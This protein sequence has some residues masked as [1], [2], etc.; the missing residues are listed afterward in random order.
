MTRN[1]LL[2][3]PS[4][5]YKIYKDSVSGGHSGTAS[6]PSGVFLP[7]LFHSFHF[8]S[9]LILSF[10]RV[11]P[12]LLS[13]LTDGQSRAALSTSPTTPTSQP[14]PHLYTVSTLSRSQTHTH[15]RT[16]AH[17]HARITHAATRTRTYT[18]TST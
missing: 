3:P 10:C 15:A 2:L 5:L 4:F 1:K 17:T 14:D 9:F 13:T 8:Q 12:S 6:S 16:H 18:G 11:V 7:F